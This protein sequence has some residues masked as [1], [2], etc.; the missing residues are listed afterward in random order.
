MFA[1]TA[2]NTATPISSAPAER[3]RR[4]PRRATSVTGARRS[5]RR[6]TH[7]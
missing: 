7:P 1:M 3:A 2:A 6:T 5:V 4:R